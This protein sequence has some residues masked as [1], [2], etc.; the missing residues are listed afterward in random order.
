MET[1]VE[2]DHHYTPDKYLRL[3]DALMIF[4]LDPVAYIQRE[5]QKMAYIVSSLSEIASS[6]FFPL[7]ES[8][9]K[10]WPAFVPGVKKQ[11]CFTENSI[12]RTS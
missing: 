1:F 3:K 4:T 6:W 12:I 10:D 5:K 11:F 8:Y 2:L 9:K 7:H